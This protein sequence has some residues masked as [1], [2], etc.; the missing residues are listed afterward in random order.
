M[1]IRFLSIICF[2]SVIFASCT[3]IPQYTFLFEDKWLEGKSYP[4]EIGFRDNTE[5]GDVIVYYNTGIGIEQSIRLDYKNGSYR[6]VIP[7]VN[8]QR[9]ILSFKFGITVNGELKFTQERFMKVL[10]LNDYVAELKSGLTR[11]VSLNA[12]SF[13]SYFN[14]FN[15]GIKVAGATEGTKVTLYYKYNGD[16]EYRELSLERSQTSFSTT[17]IPSGNDEKDDFKYYIEVS[18]PYEDF[19]P[20]SVQLPFGASNSFNT[21][22]ILDRNEILAQI[23]SE[24]ARSI[25]IDTL[26]N[27]SALYD[28]PVSVKLRINPSSLLFELMESS[29]DLYFRYSSDNNQ[30]EFRELLMTKNSDFY[31]V[32]IPSSGLTGSRLFYRIKARISLD[33]IGDVYVE[34]PVGDSPYM[35]RIMDARETRDLIVHEIR[36]AAFHEA[37]DSVREIDEVEIDLSLNFKSGAWFTRNLDME[38]VSVYLVCSRRG[39]YQSEVAIKSTYENN[40]FSAVVPPGLLGSGINSYFF[41]AQISTGTVL[42]DIEV[43]IPDTHL[44]PLNILTL[45]ELRESA[46][47]NL[48]ERI[49]IQPVP[50]I[51]GLEDVELK[52]DVRDIS[53]IKS[54]YIFLKRPGDTDWI[55]RP[56]IREDN[57]FFTIITAEE[58]NFGY[59]QY[60]FSFS[61][62]DAD[63]GLIEVNMPENG[64]LAPNQFILEDRVILFKQLQNELMSSIS[65]SNPMRINY[66][67]P[68]QLM[69]SVDNSV[70]DKQVFFLFRR[71]AGGSFIT[72]P[73]I[74]YGD[75]FYAEIPEVML[76]RESISFYIKVSES[77]PNFGKVTVDLPNGNRLYRMDVV[78]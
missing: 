7:G 32:E 14:E 35:V 20:I 10:S 48:T 9:G 40:T 53:S 52:A 12:P 75:T 5:I 55:I 24:L 57:S 71:A 33:V 58:I 36:E 66:W 4:V 31:S 51:S 72:V 50:R 64:K 34:L 76:N 2:V 38:R 73:A 45:E 18:E 3:T 6:G 59:I 63:L 69:L 25:R 67:N 17:I 22:H 47:K 44:I 62:E 68:E 41:V 70:G 15:I 74:S 13:A 11:R 77:V 49:S 39:S 42:G 8:I 27:G 1:K 43:R 61:E 30:G 19:G 56:M 16:S 65:F 23:K 29:P 21:I 28:F 78:K 46:V 37:P 26:E 54:A 60:Y